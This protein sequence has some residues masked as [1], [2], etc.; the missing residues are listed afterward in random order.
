[1]KRGA[2]RSTLHAIR[3][4]NK[5]LSADDVALTAFARG[6]P[7]AI[8]AVSVPNGT[9]VVAAIALLVATLAL[10]MFASGAA[11]AQACAAQATTCTID[12]TLDNSPATA[13]IGNNTAF[14]LTVGSST[15]GVL[16]IDTGTVTSA[17]GT[18]GS[19]SGSSG[20]VTVTGTGS[21]WNSSGGISVGGS[22][23]GL[24]IVENGATVS[25]GSAS[26][27]SVGSGSGG[28]GT[29]TIQTGGMVTDL[30][31][32][33]GGITGSTGTVTVSGTNS[34]WTNTGAL[35]VGSFG[36][37]MLTIDGGGRVT[38]GVNFTTLVGSNGTGTV[39]VDGSTL[40]VGTLVVGGAAPGGSATPAGTGALVIQD[41]GTVSS[42]GATIGS[43]AGSSGAVTV[44]GPG[45]AW[46][47]APFGITVGSSGTGTLTI[48]DSGTVSA[49]AFTVGTLGTLNIGAP[50]SEAAAPPGT[51]ITSTVTNSGLI[52]FNLT[53]TTTF[54][55]V[56]VGTGAVDVVNGTTVMTGSST[57]SGPTTIFGATLAAGGVNVF[58]PNSA[59]DV[60]SAGT[61]NLQSNNQTV[62][63]LS[64]A[65]TVQLP[66]TL[67][68]SAPG[69]VL[70]VANNYI[71]NNGTLVLNTYLGADDSPS[72]K[73]VVNGAA[74]G[75]TGLNIHNVGG[76]G[77]ETTGNGILV[78]QTTSTTAN[79]FT[80][81]DEVRGGAID[82]RLFL[83]GLGDPPFPTDWFLRS[84][85]ESP[86]GPGPTEPIGP[87]PPPGVLPPGLWPII[88]PELATY[89]VVQPTARELGLDTLG[90]LHERIGDTLTYGGADC[91]GGPCSEWG[92][93]FGQQVDNHYQA[94]ADPRDSGW[95]GGF[96][97]GVDLWRSH[98][99]PGYD[100]A[101][102]YFAYGNANMSVNGL[103]T[104]A[105]ATG[106]ALT[107]TGTV[108]LD[109]FSAGGYWTHYGSGGWYL[110]A[111][112]QGTYYA[113]SAA[114]QFADLPLN[115][116]GFISS[117][118]AGYPVPLPL[119]PHFVV[120]P[121]A[122]IIW[123]QVSFF[124]AFDGEGTVG[125]GTTSGATGRLGLRGMWTINSENGEIWQ[126]Y[127]RANLWRDWGAEA[128]TIFGTDPVPLLEQAT[129]LEFGGGLTTKINNSLSFYAQAGYQLAV[130][131]I[132]EDVER[133]A[134]QG[135][136][137]LRYTW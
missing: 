83:G 53:G 101:G 74:E 19:G 124:Q 117:L 123:Q 64:N 14:A 23:T 80:L 78:V 55:P 54:S 127:L 89:G 31:G 111:V 104:N 9:R 76:P 63:S 128:T 71:G 52:V 85:F 28:N 129:R 40:A 79:A 59:Y 22:G 44:T 102:I 41:A 122:Q 8:T 57:Y 121:Q 112:L 136:V 95:M 113:G 100:A 134:V 91:T 26:T 135:D 68:I 48:Q 61:L 51:L 65:G 87:T 108:S 32:T 25:T 36:M 62:G 107:H 131:Q 77:A 45:S 72:D 35:S 2:L 38:S 42:R 12:Q 13:P 98:M 126:P 75:S 86:E 58:S 114:T 133:N 5:Q 20:A 96:Q 88:G 119:G 137:G 67:G 66:E 27:L 94:F 33:I 105:A 92:R 110:D 15:V 18:I 17:A 39:V 24:L 50:A 116:D 93:F 84:T 69:T 29:L 115:G 4:S 132:A 103:V 97:G 106:Y 60:M 73:L 16:T 118:E 6:A 43:T 30:N 1:M 70:T 49:G 81:N 34:T 11:N 47:A 21:A 56:I 130:S 125:L 109:A 82:Y 99:L 46:T 120:E 3:S 7:T 10:D 37:G 90:T